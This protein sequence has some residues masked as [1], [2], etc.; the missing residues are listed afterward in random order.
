MKDFK[1][2]LLILVTCASL[3]LSCSTPLV[4]VLEKDKERVRLNQVQRKKESVKRSNKDSTKV[5]SKDTEKLLKEGFFESKDE[6]GMMNVS[7]VDV[8]VV[9]KNKN[10]PE[11]SGKVA[12]DF[13]VSVPASLVNNKWQVHILPFAYK[14]GKKIQFDKILVSGAQFMK[15]QEKGYQMYQDFLNSII[16]DS[17]YMQRLFDEKGY[18]KALFHLEEQ[19]YQAWIKEGF[20]ASR[21]VDWKNSWNKRN[22]LFNGIME[23][24][25]ASVTPTSWKNSFA[26]HWLER[27][28][29]A[30]SGLWTEFL[31]P[32][33]TYEQRTISS[34]DSIALSKRF[35]DYKSMLE[36]ER[37]KALV[38]EKYNEY[39]RFPRE[40]CRLDT[41]IRSGNKFEYYYS[42]NIDIDENIRKIDVMLDGEVIAL[43]ESK[44]QFPH[45]DTLTYYISSMVQ[46]LDPAPRYKRVIISRQAQA[47]MPAYINFAAGSATFSESVGN[48]KEEIDRVLETMHKLTF[49]GELVLDSVNMVATAS[50]EGN[51]STNLRLSELRARE[52]KNYLEKR[53]DD[54]ETMALFHPRALGEDWT[55]L[56]EL[57]RHDDNIRNTDEIL[58]VIGREKND[59]VRELA[60]RKFADYSYIRQELYPE[61]RAVNFNFHLHRREMVQDTIVTTVID[62]TYMDAVQLLENRQYREALSVLSEYNDRNT[63]VCLMSMGYDKRAIS[64]LETLPQDDNTLYLLAILYVRENRINE[65]INSFSRACEL[66]ISKWYRG[67]LD[68]E[69]HKLINDHNLNFE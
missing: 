61:L 42:Q 47:S 65:A 60:L 21:F 26:D 34:E 16:P 2:K 49:T 69:I 7:L 32:E 35:F 20:S 52:L 22:A 27:G 62:T 37:K 68:P 53:V 13:M 24:N 5:Y 31:S 4:S 23:R 58:E 63:A 36:N 48:N 6:N 38:D 17:T 41:V 3:V 11:R 39:V 18:Q 29:A 30:R 67:T 40:A 25:K 56:T 19:F 45:S 46:F 33:Y 59:D 1:N 57:I 64:V 66:D 28:L 9:A 55:K 51:S 54:S 12:I 15:Q 8:H 44:Y 14:N 50:P 43:D 10:I